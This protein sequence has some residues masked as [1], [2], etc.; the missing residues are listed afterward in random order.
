VLHSATIRIL[1]KTPSISDQTSLPFHK[2]AALH[3]LEL[4]VQPICWNCV[5]SRFNGR[6][7]LQKHGR[8]VLQKHGRMV[9][10][11]NTQ[12]RSGTARKSAPSSARAAP[13]YTPGLQ[14]FKFQTSPRFANS[15]ADCGAWLTPAKIVTTCC[16]SR[17]LCSFEHAK[18]HAPHP[19]QPTTPSDLR[20]SWC[21]MKHPCT[22]AAG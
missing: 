13:T 11:W 2:Y 5:L 8:M 20:K 10:Q 6:L 1:P 18:G 14:L 16:S 22:P 7:I 4:L 17:G 15:N 21:G 12:N 3:F 9:L 19:C